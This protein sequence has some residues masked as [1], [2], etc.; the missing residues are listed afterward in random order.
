MP[1][2]AA[3]GAI[4]LAVSAWCVKRAM[5]NHMVETSPPVP[6]AGAPV[7][8]ESGE[9]LPVSI[10]QEEV[11]SVLNPAVRETGTESLWPTVPL[12]RTSPQGMISPSLPSTQR[13]AAQTE[14][15]APKTASAASVI[16]G[17]SAAQAS[18]PA[19]ASVDAIAASVTFSGGSSVSPSAHPPVVEL[20]PGVPIPAALVE[21]QGQLPPAAEAARQQVADSFV[22]D[23]EE[24]VSAPG[25]EGDDVGARKKYDEAVS[26]SNE[27]YRALYG[28]AAYNQQG[29]RAAMETQTGN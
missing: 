17:G 28:D 20:E 2:L 15:Q 16:N 9:R 14:S 25:L 3:G 21:P 24:S 29:I 8:E 10:R 23:V 1:I 26:R 13:G 7:F 6:V 5:E 22:E 19:S 4:V 27:Q 11:S 18:A 12:P